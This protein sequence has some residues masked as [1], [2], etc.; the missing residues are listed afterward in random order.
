MK[1][2]NLNLIIPLLVFVGVLLNLSSCQKQQQT[3]TNKSI[4]DEDSQEVTNHILD[5]KERMELVRETPGLKTEIKYP[6]P[7]ATTELENLINFNYGYGM[8]QVNNQE[9]IYSEITMPLDALSKIGES[10]L[11]MFYYEQLIGL[12]Q[13]QMMG[14]SYQN[15]KLLFVDLE[16]KGT[17]IEGDAIIGVSSVIGNEGDIQVLTTEN[18][19][20]YG[21]AYGDCEGNTGLD[22]AQLLEYNQNEQNTTDLPPSG[23]KWRW[24]NIVTNGPIEPNIEENLNPNDDTPE[25]NYQDYLI[26]YANSKFNQPEILRDEDKCMSTDSEYGWNLE[27]SFYEQSY[28]VIGNNAMFTNNG[29]QWSLNIIE[30]NGPDVDDYDVVTHSLYI[31]SSYRYASP[32]EDIIIED[33]M[34]DE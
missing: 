30:Y 8:I 23:Y 17:T 25:D 13:N 33:I 21:F 14:L 20:W 5:F 24:R 1:T 6:A 3:H 11:S 28:S 26:F 2:F 19:W 9:I 29:N 4:V 10:K 34:S 18:G 16:H 7:D 32:I 12:I 27:M 22:A 31:T 15:M